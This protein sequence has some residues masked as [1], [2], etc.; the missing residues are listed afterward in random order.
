MKDALYY[1]KRKGYYEHS[2]FIR[3][4]ILLMIPDAAQYVRNILYC[5]RCARVSK[6]IV[7]DITTQ[8][9][10]HRLKRKSIV[11]STGYIVG[12]KWVDSREYAQRNI[13]EWCSYIDK[14]ND[15][16]AQILNII[17]NLGYDPDKMTPGDVAARIAK[18]DVTLSELCGNYLDSISNAKDLNNTSKHLLNIWGEEDFTQTTL[19]SVDYYLLVDGVKLSAKQLMSDESEKIIEQI[20]IDIIDYMLELAIKNNH[21]NRFYIRHDFDTAVRGAFEIIPAIMLPPEKVCPVKVSYKKNPDGRWYYTDVCWD[22]EYEPFPEIR[23]VCLCDLTICGAKYSQIG[24]FTNEKIDVYRGGLLIGEYR[25]VAANRDYL[26]FNQYKYKPGILA[27][28]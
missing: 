28:E 24:N 18:L 23:L 8:I 11:H 27:K 16:I 15:G 14:T 6:E 3:D 5:L 1:E 13:R 26:F 9:S 10:E 4:L 12:N 22:I 2:D 20:I 17:F 19:E 7:S 25:Q 21:N